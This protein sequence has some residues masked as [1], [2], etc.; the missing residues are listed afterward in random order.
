M[1]AWLVVEFVALNLVRWVESSWF[2]FA[3][4][5]DGFAFSAAIN[6]GN[7]LALSAAPLL[8]YRLPFFACSHIWAVGRLSGGVAGR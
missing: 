2:F 1:L 8:W 7:Y 5:T 6:L 4:G 3:R